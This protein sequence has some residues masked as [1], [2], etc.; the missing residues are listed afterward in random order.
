MAEL[1]VIGCRAGSPGGES[2]ASGYV[3][4]VGG[5]TLL[6]DC[7]PGVVAGL[8]ARDL[9][10]QLD[11]VIVTHRHADH[12]ADLV[13][14]AYHRLFPERMAPLP[15]YGPAELQGTLT[16]L[17][18]VFGIRS[19]PELAAP[20]V[21]ALPL[22]PL[23]ADATE[24]VAGMA[25]RTLSM[26]HPV[27]TLA[28]HFSDVGLSYTSDGTLTEALCRFVKGS[29]TLLAEATYLSSRGADLVGHGHMT[30]VQAGTLARCAGVRRL[31]LTHLT[32][33]A[34]ADASREEAQRTFAGKVQVAAPGLRVSL[35]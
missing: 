14:L 17:D 10:R 32:D 13:A 9:I 11:A 20:L 3:L 25:V 29:S 1:L 4:F 27:A 22:K 5:K 33:Y 35:T 26:V 8:A 21:A 31:I 34:Y 15:L 2:P 19:L 12:C 23:S 24:E 16:A 18:H 30:A 28:L 6:I 7:G